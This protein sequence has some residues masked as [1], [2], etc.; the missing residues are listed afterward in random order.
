MGEVAVHNS[1][2]PYVLTSWQADLQR[3]SGLSA[4]VWLQ[5]SQRVPITRRTHALGPGT[6]RQT[7]F[8]SKNARYCF[9]ACCNKM[10]SNTSPVFVDNSACSVDDVADIIAHAAGHDDGRIKR[11]CALRLPRFCLALSS[12]PLEDSRDELGLRAVPPSTCCLLHLRPSHLAN[13]GPFL[14]HSIG[15]RTSPC[16]PPA[17][18]ATT[19]KMHMSPATALTLSRRLND[20]TSGNSRDPAIMGCSWRKSLPRRSCQVLTLRA[21]ASKLA[22]TPQH[23]A[24]GGDPI[25]TQGSSER[26]RAQ[27]RPR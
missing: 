27:H 2:E 9:V 19:P 5:L 7:P 11:R 20:F 13:S 18:E 8:D 6:S 10:G 3:I 24:H 23:A 16:D 15:L 26:D 1:S 25:S 21:N 14:I 17:T 4:S 22:L 12:Q